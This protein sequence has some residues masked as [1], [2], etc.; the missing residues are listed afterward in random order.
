MR[1]HNSFLVAA[2]E[3]LL[4]GNFTISEMGAMIV[5]SDLIKL[6]LRDHSDEVAWGCG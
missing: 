1:L 6:S 4:F 5:R 3:N 2:A